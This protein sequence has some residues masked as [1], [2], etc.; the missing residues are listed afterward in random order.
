MTGK[1]VFDKLPRAPKRAFSSEL[2]V[3]LTR[4][5]NLKYKVND[6]IYLTL[7]NEEV[8]KIITIAKEK[9]TVTY[10]ELVK[11]I[12]KDDVTFKDLSLSKKEYG[13][14]IEEVKKKLDISKD[15]KLEVSK[16][17]NAEKKV[18]NKL[19]NDKLLRKTF[20]EL[21]GYH[22]LKSAINSC[23]N[24]EVWQSVSDNIEFLDELALYCTNYKVNDDILEKIKESNVIDSMFADI[25]FV[26]K[27]PNFK[28]HVMLSTNIIR[29]L[30]PL[31]LDGNT[32]DKAM[33]ILGY[34][35]SDIYGNKNRKRRTC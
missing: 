20:I 28:D 11:V 4:L 17:N 22:A 2:F 18:Y 31:M 8:N 34:N 35:H 3:T 26:E 23:Y 21:K 32:Y 1:C 9:K 25:N 30:I 13:K 5:V 29:K 33:N 27:L 12:N 7:T 6:S 10:K 24:K 14:L 16:L 15:V 19:Y